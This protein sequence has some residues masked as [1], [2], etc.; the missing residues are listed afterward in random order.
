MLTKNNVIFGTPYL[1]LR[2]Y[3]K[4]KAHFPIEIFSSKIKLVLWVVGP[5]NKKIKYANQ[6]V[7]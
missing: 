3:K 6:N 1:A 5:K 2:S 7:S 4:I